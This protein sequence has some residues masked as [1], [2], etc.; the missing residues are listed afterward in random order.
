MTL[1]AGAF[2]IGVAAIAATPMRARPI[3]VVVVLAGL[4]LWAT[5]AVARHRRTEH[6]ERTALIA[7]DQPEGTA[8]R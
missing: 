4:G 1:G 2:S 3:T 7:T 8:Q 5:L 6:E